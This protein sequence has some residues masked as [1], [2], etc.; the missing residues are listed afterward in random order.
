MTG[1]SGALE[2]AFGILN[3]YERY[4]DSNVDGCNDYISLASGR[5]VAYKVTLAPM[6][7]LT[8]TVDAIC[9]TCGQ[10]D[11]IDEVIYLL[12]T[13]SED[14]VNFPSGEDNCVMGADENYGGFDD[15][16]TFTYTHSGAESRDYYI[17]IDTWCSAPA[18]D[19]SF[20]CATSADGFTLTWNIQ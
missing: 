19:N 15:L 9:N 8:V 11:H 5:E 4:G 13:C 18:S 1:A 12:N 20:T 2:G 3:D 17:V 6:D 14:G 16:E 10:Y 7:V